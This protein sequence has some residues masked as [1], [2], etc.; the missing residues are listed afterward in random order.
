MLMLDRAWDTDC[1]GRFRCWQDYP[2]R[3]ICESFYRVVSGSILVDGN[4]CDNSFQRKT[5]YVQQQ[6]LHRSADVNCPGSSLV[7]G[8]MEAYT[9]AVVGIPGEGLNVEQHKRLTIGVELAAKPQLLLFLDEPYVWSG[10]SNHLVYLHSPWSICTLLDH[11]AEMLTSILKHI[12]ILILP[13]HRRTQSPYPETPQRDGVLRSRL[14]SLAVHPPST[15]R[16][17]A[18]ARVYALRAPKNGLVDTRAAY[19]DTTLG[20]LS[21]TLTRHRE[22]TPTREEKTAPML[23]PHY[24]ARRSAPTGEDGWDDVPTGD[25]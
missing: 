20:M 11:D 15:S 14:R 24:K 19:A 21:Y 1:S 5:G 9:D 22:T 12:P 6:D 18:R 16:V 7:R 17:V 10:Q 2:P 4:P 13:T 25:G 8:C 3:R 23:H